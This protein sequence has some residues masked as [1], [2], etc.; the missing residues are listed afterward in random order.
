MSSHA[1]DLT[2]YVKSISPSSVVVVTGE[3]AGRSGGA[4]GGVGCG[5]MMTSR[6]MDL[7]TLNST[8]TSRSSPLPRHN[9][10]QYVSHCD[11]VDNDDDDVVYL[12]LLLLDYTAWPKI[13][14]LKFV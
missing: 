14:V 6:S 13:N 9:L 2:V 5:Q 8:A 1:R 10:R 7:S 3:R 12:L 4:V 11:H